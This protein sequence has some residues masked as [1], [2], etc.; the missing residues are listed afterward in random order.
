[1]GIVTFLIWM[2]FHYYLNFTIYFLVALGLRCVWT[3]SW[4]QQVGLFSSCVV[5]SLKYPPAAE[6][7]PQGTWAQ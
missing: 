5:V 4:L 6:H 2:P 1:M 7:W 3:F